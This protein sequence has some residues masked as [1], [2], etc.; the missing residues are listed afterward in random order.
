MVKKL[1]RRSVG[2][3]KVILPNLHERSAMK[4]VLP[5]NMVTSSPKIKRRPS[6]LRNWQSNNSNGPQKIKAAK[7]LMTKADTRIILK[8]VLTISALTKLSFLTLSE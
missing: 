5:C 1:G 7:E 4:E 3:P 6:L 2:K 8:T